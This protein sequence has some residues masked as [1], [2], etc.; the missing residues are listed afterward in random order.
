MKLI[1]TDTNVLFDVIKIGAL[2]E[3]FSLDYD[4]CTTVFVIEEIKP[5][6]Q[7]ELVDTFI[8]AKKLTVIE[9][10]GEDVEDVVN[11]DTVKGLKRFTDK[12][13]IWK[14]VQL[15]CPMLTGD[16]KMKE[17][18]ENIGIE[19]HGS[20]WVIDELYNYNLISSEK[21]IELLEQ[22]LKT[23]SWLP[24]NEIERRIN[25]LK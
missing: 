14:S 13:V 8:R 12:S 15:N 4:I 10:T 25:K 3:F 23:N 2:P 1:I 11:F 7:R 6:G 19:V 17:I 22:L 5:S 21:A 16:K 20:I 24:R 18:A 9:F